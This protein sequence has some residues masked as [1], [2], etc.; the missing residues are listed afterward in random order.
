M[1]NKKVL[2]EKNTKSIELKKRMEQKGLTWISIILV[3]IIGRNELISFFQS[4]SKGLSDF[5]D[6]LTPVALVVLLIIFIWWLGN[7]K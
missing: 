7:R 6:S 5:L 3:A 2:K 1:K 4:F